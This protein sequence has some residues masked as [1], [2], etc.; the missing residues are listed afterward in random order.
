MK[1]PN[2]VNFV[3]DSLI[4]FGGLSAAKQ[5]GMERPKLWIFVVVTSGIGSILYGE[6]ISRIYKQV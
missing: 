1:K 5:I 2:A 6:F 3:F 4:Y